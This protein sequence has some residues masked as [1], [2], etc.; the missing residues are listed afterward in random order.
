M[1]GLS[2]FSVGSARRR[3]GA[4]TKESSSVLWANNLTGADPFGDFKFE[5]TKYPERVTFPNTSGSPDGKTMQVAFTSGSTEPGFKARSRFHNAPGLSTP[6]V[7]LDIG[8]RTEVTLSY[9][10]YVSSASLGGILDKSTSKWPGLIGT[11]PE[12]DGWYGSTGGNFKEDSFSS[13]IQIVKGSDFNGGSPYIIFYVYAAYANGIDFK[14]NP[15]YGSGTKYG[16]WIPLTTD[17]NNDLTNPMSGR[18][19]RVPTDKWFEIRKRIVLNTPG[20]NNGILQGWVDNVLHCDVRDVRW[21]QAGYDTKINQMD[22][23]AFVSNNETAISSGNINFA[24]IQL[25]SSI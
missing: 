23:S 12:Q 15:F 20:E 25:L 19:V 9:Q 4:A 5:V 10:V 7:H 18:N 2:L 6:G 1:S 16:I 3:Q 8:E 13:R 14:T 11:P 21:R 22:M 24:R 17:G